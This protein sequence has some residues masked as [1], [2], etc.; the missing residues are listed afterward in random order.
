[1]GINKR[2][3]WIRLPMIYFNN[4]QQKKMR[5]Q[6][7]GLLL[8]IIYLKLMLLSCNNSGIIYYQGVYNSLSE[9]I[10]E[11]IAEDP[12]EVEKALAY[13][14][15]NNL[16]EFQ[17]QDV[18]IPQAVDLIGS[19][20]QVAERVRK[21]R[22]LQCNTDVTKCNTDVTPTKHDET[23]C[24]TELELEKELE[25]ELEKELELDANV[26]PTKRIIKNFH[27]E[28]DNIH[29]SDNEYQE[30]CNTYSKI[31][32]DKT[33]NKISNHIKKKNGSGYGDK[34]ADKIREWLT[35]DYS[36]H[37]IKSALENENRLNKL[38]QYYLNGGE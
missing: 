15:S 22:A 24:N 23:K 8:Q 6:D 37:D 32:V 35:K 25:L 34:T 31:L 14:E 16:L 36:E 27:G 7:N 11:E 38:E 30:L 20:T 12:G 18:I 26:T 33:I 4:L 17:E 5:K 19:E 3:Y 9:E 1:M 29:L 10:A 13:F 2:Y 21:H 28:H